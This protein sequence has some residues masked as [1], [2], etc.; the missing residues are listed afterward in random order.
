VP[1]FAGCGTQSAFRSG[2]LFLWTG[3][4]FR[5]TPSDLKNEESDV[6]R[7]GVCRGFVGVVFGC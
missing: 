2:R 5:S 4:L 1:R 3:G 6:C 7:C